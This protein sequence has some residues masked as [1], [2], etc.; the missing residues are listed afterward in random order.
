MVA[1]VGGD[2]FLV[3]MRNTSVEEAERQAKRLGKESA[4]SLIGDDGVVNVTLSIGLSVYGVNG[5][6]YESLFA[7]ADRAMYRTK[8]NGKNSYSLAGKEIGTEGRRYGKAREREVS[9]ARMADKEFLNFAFSLLSH[10]RDISGSL[11]VLIEQIGKRYGLDMVSVFEDV[12]ERGEM[13]LMNYWNRH[14]FPCERQILPRLGESFITARPGEFVAISR[15]EFAREGE[16]AGRLWREN[17]TIQNLAVIKFE[18]SGKRIGGLY[19]GVGERE[20]FTPVEKD[21]F[22]ELSRVVSVFISLRNKLSDDQR[23]IRKLRTRMR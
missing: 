8:G 13:L 3:F 2:E 7:M 16:E 4:K 15:E 18:F 10:A 23:E 22:C 20:D 12:E 11:N 6:D 19:L 21:T 5:L 14:G 9:A 1:R 17:S